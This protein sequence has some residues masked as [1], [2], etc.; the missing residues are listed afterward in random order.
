MADSDPTTFFR[1]NYQ[2]AVWHRRRL[3]QKNG[4]VVS[5]YTGFKRRYTPFVRPEFIQRRRHMF[6]TLQEF[7]WGHITLLWG[8]N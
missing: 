5:A 8:P 6:S 1:P 7:F 4:V 2:P 3:F